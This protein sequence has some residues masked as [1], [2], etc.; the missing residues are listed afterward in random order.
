M[1]ETKPT[2][3]SIVTSEDQYIDTLS[4]IAK[5]ATDT[6]F[7]LITA[8]SK[9]AIDAKETEI[10]EYIKTTVLDES[11]RSEQVDVAIELWNQYKDL[12]KNAICIFT[13]NNLEVKT[14]DKKLHNSVE[15]DTETIFYGLHLKKHFID[16]LPNVKGDEFVTNDIL[17]TF[18]NAMALYHLLSTL[19]VKGLNKETYAFAHLLYKLSEISK[20]YQ[21]YDGV[22]LRTN[23]SIGQ[24]SMGISP[25]QATELK[26][27]VAEIA[28]SETSVPLNVPYD[29]Q[30]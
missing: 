22:S 5:T 10:V 11:T 3:E 19:K 1:K 30:A 2:N 13:L 25:T 12:V 23:Q 18:S 20:V 24:W 8:V 15:Y 16:L 7:E 6:N 14:V 27:A 26:A 4:S 28:V 9:T 17:I 29:V 21:Y